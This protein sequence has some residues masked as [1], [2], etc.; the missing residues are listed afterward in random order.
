MACT[1]FASLNAWETFFNKMYHEEKNFSERFSAIL[2]NITQ[3]GGSPHNT[4]EAIRKFGLIDQAELPFDETIQS[5]DEFYSPKPLTRHYLRKGED[6]LSQ[7]EL[8]HE[9]IWRGFPSVE[10]KV[11][12]I[13][14]ALKRSPVCISVYAWE[15]NED[16]VYI[17]SSQDTHWTMCYGWTDKGWKVFDSYDNTHKIYSFDANIAMAK[18]YWINKKEYNKEYW[19]VDLFKR[20]F[21]LK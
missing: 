21:N 9:W 14:E 17:Q 16:G 6:F 10:E 7:Y 15:K 12:N 20:L 1:V 11:K 19:F 3:Q 13:K 8:S 5:W 2:S 4:C 18:L